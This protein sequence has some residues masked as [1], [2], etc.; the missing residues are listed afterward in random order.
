MVCWNKVNIVESRIENISYSVERVL[1]ICVDK[2]DA[3]AD[4]DSYLVR[5]DS[6]IQIREKK[7]VANSRVLYRMTV[8]PTIPLGA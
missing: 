3:D 1:I 7:K 8:S 5:L 2:V 4:A 6:L